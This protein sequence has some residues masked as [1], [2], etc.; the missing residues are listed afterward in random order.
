MFLNQALGANSALRCTFMHHEQACAMAAEGYA[1]I[2]GKPA[3]VRPARVHV[4]AGP[5]GPGPQTGVN[6]VTATERPGL[7]EDKGQQDCKKAHA[8]NHNGRQRLWA[9]PGSI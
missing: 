5:A 4:A 3:V 8:P 6:G 1:R 2:A 9:P 7:L